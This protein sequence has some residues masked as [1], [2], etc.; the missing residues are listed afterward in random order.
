MAA[1]IAAVSAVLLGIVI[2]FVAILGIWLFAAHG[3]ESTL[4][5]MRASGI[6]WL[7]MH[8]VPVQ[9]SGVTIGL[10]PWGFMA[11]PITLIWKSTQWAFKSAQPTIGK[12][13]WRI[14]ILISGIYSVLSII[15]NLLTST[16][17]LRTSV[18]STAIHTFTLA[19][20]VTIACVIS[21]APSRT[22]LIDGLPEVVV[23]GLRPGLVAFGTLMVLGSAATSIALV[24]HF[25]EI[26]AVTTLMAPG[27]IDGLFL[28]L[29]CIG[30]LPTATVWSMSYLL[31]PGVL[32]GGTGQVSVGVAAPGALPAFPLLSILP[33]SVS[34][35]A[36]YLILIPILVG[37]LIYFLL[38]RE[39]WAARGDS[40]PETMSYVVR[41]RELLTMLVAVGV[42][43]A[44][45]W[46]AAAASSGSLGIGY[47]RFVGADPMAVAWATISVCGLSALLTLV[48]P[49][50]VLS[51]IHWW[52]HR[53]R[54][55]K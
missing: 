8:L 35:A 47:L 44:F 37:V 11:L 13:F 17:D 7:G 46:L 12:E 14:A 31:G 27:V 26:K 45:S 39:R 9:I 16:T 54:V 30:Y 52:S 19:L 48:L 40:F 10:L 43:A 28:T 24:L 50:V 33:S 41:A 36:S 2:S 53:E 22:M 21:Y 32:L 15:T 3:N 23:A 55:A 5:V 34:S 51:L 6:A 38:P 20:L 25:S 29:L 42:L 18:I 4:Q 49:R 1:G